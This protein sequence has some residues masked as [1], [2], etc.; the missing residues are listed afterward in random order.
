[1]NGH[2]NALALLQTLIFK[3][4]IMP[5]YNKVIMIGHLTREPLLSYT[6]SQMAVC[7]IGIATNHKY[8]DKED[9]CFIDCVA[10]G[11]S[12]ENINKFFAK[13]RAILVEG[14][15]SL[16]QWTEQDGTKRQRHKII[17]ERWS[18]ADS[19]EQ[20]EPP[21]TDIKDDDIPF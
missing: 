9:V 19:Q 18:F 14:R 3:E 1:M 7:D 17:I 8:K 16:D 12:A 10:F 11:N 13:G 21:R 15:L 4:K 5:N 20:T 2:V 6:P